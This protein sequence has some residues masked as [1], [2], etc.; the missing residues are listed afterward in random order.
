MDQAARWIV[1]L[2]CIAGFAW[3][4]LATMATVWA[5]IA[6]GSRRIAANAWVALLVFLS[7]AVMFAW[8]AVTFLPVTISI[9]VAT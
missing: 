4:V 3:A 2:L 5:T 9:G 1:S 6:F 8:L 7:L